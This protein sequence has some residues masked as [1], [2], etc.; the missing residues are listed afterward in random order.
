MPLKTP[1]YDAHAALGATFVEFAGYDMPVHY[2]SIKDE[3]AT[4]RSGVGLFDVSHMSNLW[5]MGPKAA[6]ALAKVTPSDPTAVPLGKGKY[7]V[8]L[9]EDGTILDDTFYFKVA[10]EKFYVIPNAGRNTAV[11]EQIAKHTPGVVVKD[12]TQEWAILALQGPKARDVLAA[13]SVSPAPK[14]HHLV[15]MELAGIFCMVSGTGYTGEKGVELY[16]PAHGARRVWD[17]LL[18]VGAAHGI[19][20]IGLGARDTLRLEKGYCL[21]GNE[22]EGGRTPIEANL[23]WTMDWKGDFLGKARL[24]AQKDDPTT[25]RLVGLVQ[26]KG[27]PRHGYPIERS[28]TDAGKVTS[29]TQS[30]TTGKGI[31]LGYVRGGA[32]VGET[33]EVVVREKRMPATVAKLPFV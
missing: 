10:D 22:F 21:A 4:V 19:K 1:L 26:E 25:D 27:I 32:D 16:V 13:A 14:F 31:A 3:H 6:A 20:P 15:N 28:G 18:K 23:E 24:L 11:A 17:H 5:V 8:V 12:V 9:R 33:F 30:P 7:T 2:G 29:G